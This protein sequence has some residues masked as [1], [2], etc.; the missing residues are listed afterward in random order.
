LLNVCQ[1]GS[2]GWW[3]RGA[4]RVP[5]GLP[6]SPRLDLTGVTS[7]TSGKHEEEAGRSVA[8]RRTPRSRADSAYFSRRTARSALGSISPRFLEHRTGVALLH[9]LLAGSS[10]HCRD[11]V[12]AA[13]GRSS[14]D[15]AVA[16]RSRR[17]CSPV[18]RSFSA[19]F[20]T[21]L[22]RSLEIPSSRESSA[23]VALLRSSRP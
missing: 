13:G 9:P 7:R 23:R 18:W 14:W 12:T 6:E 3:G 16:C 22:T 19:S 1:G 5:L 17:P 11:R 8:R 20:C 21:C 15:Q 10:A 2:G 4:S